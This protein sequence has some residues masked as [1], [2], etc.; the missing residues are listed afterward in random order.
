LS[1]L[2]A[3]RTDEE[4]T[5]AMTESDDDNVLLRLLIPDGSARGA[6]VGQVVTVK[7]ICAML[8]RSGNPAMDQL[9]TVPMVQRWLTE[10]GGQDLP[11]TVQRTAARELAHEF[12]KVRFATSRDS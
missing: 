10:P 1:V 7:E 2:V 6:T 11:R 9:L 8:P 4:R 12:A 3:A 5:L